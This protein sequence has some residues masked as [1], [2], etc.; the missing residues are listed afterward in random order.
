MHRNK[1]LDNCINYSRLKGI[2]QRVIKSTARECSQSYCNTVDKSTY[3][4]GSLWRMAR[5]MNVAHSEHKIKNKTYWLMAL[6]R[7]ITRIKPRHSPNS[8]RI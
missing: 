2:A 6:H 4:L 7:K 1:T 5:Q 3:K 8:S